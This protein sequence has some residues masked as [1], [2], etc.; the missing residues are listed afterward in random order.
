MRCSTCGETLQP[1]A[2]RCPTCGTST[3]VGMAITRPTGVRRCPRCQYQ[4]EGMPYFR[5]AGHVGLLIGASL[6]TYG[7]GGLV[8][9]L[10]AGSI[11]SARVAGSVGRTPRGPS[12]SRARSPSSVSSRRSRSRSSRVPASS[13]GF[14]VR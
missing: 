12:R 8:Y 6:F 13:A 5:R 14:W 1:G 7:F 4:G 3:P 11:S 10:A 9:W 2:V